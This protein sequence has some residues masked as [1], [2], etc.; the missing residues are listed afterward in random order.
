MTGG[1]APFA[2]GL[3]QQGRRA[4]DEQS[5][6]LHRLA[7][8]VR[9]LQQP[10]I[11]GRHPHQGG[12]PRHKADD[13]PG[14]EPGQKEHRPAGHQEHVD[15]HE[16]PVHVVDRQGMDQHVLGGEPPGSGQR[17]G[18]GRQ[19]VVCQ[20]RAL[21]APGGAGGVDDRR[22]V[23]ACARDR[24]EAGGL[25]G[26]KIGEAPLPGRVQRFHPRAGK[27]RE[28]LHALAHL[29][30]ADDQR[31]LGVGDEIADLRQ[32]VGA[33]ERQIDRSCPEARQIEH[34]VGGGFLDSHGHPV[35]G[36][37]AQRDQGARHPARCL[38]EVPEGKP[39][40]SRRLEREAF[41]T[42]LVAQ[43]QLEK[44]AHGRR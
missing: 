8:Q 28:V 15:G 36:L 13:L 43:Q 11:E 25:A 19:V 23:A 4:G 34:Q 32:G 24:L 3:G 44:I 42:G 29:R 27:A 10:G 2:V 30:I 40:A 39:K 31:R 16:Q 7:T 33:V 6:P 37:H 17:P 22:Q 21:R 38:E 41:G 20:H 1:L 14:V 18:I 5:H 12:R 26:G 35:A 9:M